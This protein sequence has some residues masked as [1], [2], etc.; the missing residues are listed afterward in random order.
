MRPDAL[1]VSSIKTANKEF[2]FKD[3]CLYSCLKQIGLSRDQNVSMSKSSC[4][5]CAKKVLPSILF[6]I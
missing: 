4:R 1:C 3:A 5:K 6:C 2:N